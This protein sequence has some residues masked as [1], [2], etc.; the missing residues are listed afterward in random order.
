MSA[1]TII[2]H[3]SKAS[4]C[5]YKTPA[6]STNNQVPLLAP[7]TVTSIGN[8][9]SVLAGLMLAG[10]DVTGLDSGASEDGFKVGKSSAA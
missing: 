5:T 9:L 6:R 10:L 1:F 4:R 8:T 2:R 3:S 7:F